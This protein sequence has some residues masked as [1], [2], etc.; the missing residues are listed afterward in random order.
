M[1][2]SIN[3]KILNADKIVCISEIITNKSKSEISF[4][5]YFEGGF[6][7][8]VISQYDSF[9]DTSLQYGT[10]LIIQLRSSILLLWQGFTHGLPSY[11]YKDAVYEF[12]HNNLIT[13]P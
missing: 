4:N 9:N 2:F 12:T 1:F 3:N 6:I 10:N 13:T 5:I 7:F 11:I 8:N